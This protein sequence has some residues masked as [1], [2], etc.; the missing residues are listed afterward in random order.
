MCAGEASGAELS[1]TRSPHRSLPAAV[2]DIYLLKDFGNNWVPSKYGG[3]R[4]R[5]QNT[6]CD[7]KKHVGFLPTPLGCDTVGSNPISH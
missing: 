6:S 2:C 1:V 7:F 4:G 3:G 5:G